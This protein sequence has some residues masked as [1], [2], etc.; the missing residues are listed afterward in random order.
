MGL[1]QSIKT[2]LFH[3]TKIGPVIHLKKFKVFLYILC[4]GLVSTLPLGKV[5]Y[6]LTKELQ[7]NA[8][9]FVQNMPQDMK[10]QNNELKAKK[11]SGFIYQGK[12]GTFVFDPD[13]KE[14]KTAL[15]E[16]SKESNFAV[17]FQQK[18]VALALAPNSFAASMFGQNYFTLSYKEAGFNGLTKANLLQLTSTKQL[19]LAVVITCVLLSFFPC[20]I[21]L[22]LNLLMTS[23]IALFYCKM[24]N[25]PLRFGQCFKLVVFCSTWPLL[26][27]GIS[28]FFFSNVF[29]A[30]YLY[31]ATILFFIMVINTNRKQN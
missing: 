28:Q 2:V 30:N 4:L 15:K 9:T 5:C 13:N 3:P 11:G 6:D 7:N 8:Q 22:L 29:L 31:F 20:L 16:Q 27:A 10:I 14:K 1:F 23:V 21:N 26:V 19:S 25:V 18:Q 17:Q 12:I 24:T